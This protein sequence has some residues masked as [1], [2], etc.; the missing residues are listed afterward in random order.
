[1]VPDQ[2]GK[3]LQIISIFLLE[4]FLVVEINKIKKHIVEA[5]TVIAAYM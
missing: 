4:L 3:K 1:M 2:A 5:K